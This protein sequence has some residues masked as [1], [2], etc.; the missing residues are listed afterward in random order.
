MKKIILASTIGVVFA[1]GA[2]IAVAAPDHNGPARHAPQTRA[3]LVSR[4]DARFAALDINKDGKITAEER[5]AQK[6][7]RTQA[8]FDRLDTDKN[9]QISRAEF[10]AA[11]AK[12]G[13]EM[14][15][16]HRGKRMMR[17][18]GGFEAMADANKDGVVTR[19]EFQSRA[20]ARFD[21][22]DTNKDGTI[23]DEERAA[24]RAAWKA[25]RAK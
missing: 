13:G 17:H 14:R 19:D 8:L 4:L 24:A 22:I 3:E 11:H 9:G 25:K 7:A 2:G 20:L 18:H 1:A 15:G 21:S 10:D 16:E 5:A 6:A 23:S 12:R